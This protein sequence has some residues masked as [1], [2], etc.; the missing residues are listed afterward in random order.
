MAN[1]VGTIVSIEEL[2]KTDEITMSISKDG[3]DFPETFKLCKDRTYTIPDFQ[4]EIKWEPENLLELINDISVGSKFLG[5]V[6]LSKEGNQEYYIIDGQ[7]RITMLIMLI[8]YLKFNYGK[9][10][11]HIFK[12][13]NFNVESFLGFND[14]VEN[15]YTLT[16]LDNTKTCEI[17]DSDLYHQIEQYEKLYSSIKDSNRITNSN[18]ARQFYNNLSRCT[19]NVITSN[20]NDT[21]ESI[22]YFLDVN[23][24]GVKLDN[25]DIFKAYLFDFD[26]TD[27]IK[28]AWKEFKS[29]VF[30]VN[31]TTSGSGKDIYPCM[32]IIEHYLYCD[33][34]N[35]AKFK[36]LDFN[37]NF[38]L[39]KNFEKDEE[40]FSIGT[41]VVKVI[42][43]NTYM[44]KTF[45]NIN[46][47]LK[48][49]IDVVENSSPS[50]SFSK[51]FSRIDDKEKCIIHNIIRKTLCDAKLLL[52]KAL[53]M[54]YILYLFSF[55][56]P[57]K[58]QIKQIYSIFFLNT[59]F[60]LF[61]TKKEKNSILNILK[62]TNWQDKVVS[63]VKSYFERENIVTNKFTSQYKY[64][65][66]INNDEQKYR[67]KSLAAIY[68]F[69]EITNKTVSVKKGMYC[70]FHKF[71]TDD[72]TFSIEHFVINDGKTMNV[73]KPNGS[74]Y[75]YTYISET[76]KYA[77]S[78]F[79][80]IFIPDELNQEKLCNVSVKNKNK[81]LSKIN[82][83]EKIK[84]E[85]SKMVIQ[86]AKSKFE[87]NVDINNDNDTIKQKYDEYFAYKFKREYNNFV[88]EILNNIIDKFKSKE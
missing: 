18:S 10:I 1:I 71:L 79:N 34:Y 48:F 20:S 72:N 83:D 49:I 25:E 29:N 35:N 42:G 74:K 53:I 81:K 12:P 80:F 33:L 31:S 38:N 9:Q 47:Y 27:D 30:K 88:D 6:I 7:Q 15:H 65:T 36:S 70:E 23:L 5:N 59:M 40:I 11:T 54:K 22:E 8:N 66:D 67:C 68:N 60:T 78:I 76:K 16:G 19:V 51:F 14:F 82:I 63:H 50:V 86:I 61:E 4:R 26:R 44:L 24:K 41:H 37:E 77:K 13:C 85:Y 52:P 64:A 3:N 57:N 17:L 73:V 45:K 21:G 58:A 62:S 75:D 39:T 32:K 69:F 55:D 43:D 28:T 46:K 87:E 2:L 84:C 56:N